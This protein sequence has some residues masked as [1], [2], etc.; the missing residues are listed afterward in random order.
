MTA[1]ARQTTG[2]TF[3]MKAA[4]AGAFLGIVPAASADPLPVIA[5]N[6]EIG[7]S[8][9]GT[10][11]DIE[12]R[13]SDRYTFRESYPLFSG[14]QAVSSYT[15]NT[16][17]RA[18][19]NS[20]TPGFEANA[21]VMFDIGRIKHF[22][23]SGNFDLG[24]GNEHDQS[25]ETSVSSYGA[26]GGRSQ[27]NRNRSY[28]NSWGEIG[29]GFLLNGGRLLITPVIQGGYYSYG[30][31]YSVSYPASFP[32]FTTPLPSGT[33]QY[34]AHDRFSV[35]GNGYVGLAVHADYAL[36]NALVLRGRAGWARMLDTHAFIDDRP[37]A[38]HTATRPLWQGD[39]G[40]DYRI[41]RHFHLTGGVH[42][43]Y[44]DFGRARELSQTNDNLPY[45]SFASSE[46]Q[47]ST[48]W[49]N[50]VNLRMGVAYGF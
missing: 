38:Y 37:N 24:D 34:I 30:P 3:W 12:H 49:I 8:A 25:A 4:L 5:V 39:I 23:A 48:S 50:G 18:R 47:R 44:L 33:P 27:G 20:W 9:L 10:F 40:L 31:R 6:R 21:Q 19:G 15:N 41:T 28:T 11:T 26:Y 36:T 7:L 22:Y 1:T 17:Q 45:F 42:Y 32:V 16:Y 14:G 2:Q 43:T 46:T 13:Y 29:K 35:F